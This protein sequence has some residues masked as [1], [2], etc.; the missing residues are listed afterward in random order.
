MGCTVHIHRLIDEAEQAARPHRCF[1]FWL[2]RNLLRLEVGGAVLGITRG[3]IRQTDEFRAC[4]HLMQFGEE[5]IRLSALL[6][7]LNSS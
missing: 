2:I 5:E 1:Q 7:C 4:P 6:F 3:L